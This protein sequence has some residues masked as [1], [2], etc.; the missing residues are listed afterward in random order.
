MSPI[1]PKPKTPTASGISRLLSAAG[2]DRAVITNN[3]RYH[4]EHTEG[5]HVRKHPGSVLVAHWS[6]SVSPSA[7][8]VAF[9]QAERRSER[10]RLEQYAQVIDDAGFCTEITASQSLIV[11]A[12]ED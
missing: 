12:K 6:A 11:T 7:R 2:F 8:T 3:S 1:T 10:V 4:K 5:F 9:V